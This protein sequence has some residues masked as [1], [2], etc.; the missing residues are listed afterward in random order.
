MEYYNN[1]NNKSIA[2]NNT[3]HMIIN[4]R[5][6]LYEQ[7]DIRLVKFYFGNPMKHLRYDAVTIDAKRTHHLSASSISFAVITYEHV[8][9]MQFTRNLLVTRRATIYEDKTVKYTYVY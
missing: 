6:S 2:I 3:R 1:V 7:P 4:W 9:A 8:S 5:T